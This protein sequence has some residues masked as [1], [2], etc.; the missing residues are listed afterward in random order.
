MRVLVLVAL[1]VALIPRVSMAQRKG[2]FVLPNVFIGAVSGGVGAAINRRPGERWPVAF[3]RGGMAG[4]VGGFLIYQGKNA[5][6]RVVTTQRLAYA[7]PARLIDAAGNSLVENAAAN[8]GL[9]DRGHLNL[10]FVRFE[11]ERAPLRLRPRILPA[12]L[13]GTIYVA[14]R[15]AFD[16]ASSLRTGLLVF[17]TSDELHGQHDVTAVTV[18]NSILYTTG[19]ATR[20][21][22]E[23]IAHEIIHSM[24]YDD[25]AGFTYFL[26]PLATTMFESRPALGRIG[27][28][29]HPDLHYAGFL[30]NYFVFQGGSGRSYCSNTL[31]Q[32]A[33]FLSSPLQNC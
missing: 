22:P 28:W 15:G 26:R 14:S 33:I 5:V 6:H 21:L 12:A 27:R 29:V 1:V 30:V 24:Q 25:Y 10:G 20:W 9:L 8:R 17:H 11:I 31:E 4:A 32:E 3:L 7:W 2:D 13:A 23:T 16:P 19:A 18:V